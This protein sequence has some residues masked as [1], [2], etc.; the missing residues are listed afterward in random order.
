MHRQN[1]KGAARTREKTRKEGR[2]N[3]GGVCGK[4]GLL[5]QSS[6]E[7]L[8]LNKGARSSWG[9]MGTLF[10]SPPRRALAGAGCSFPRGLLREFTPSESL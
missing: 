8:P 9:G 7:P 10:P 3:L 2:G 6:P 1:L 4:K 5:L